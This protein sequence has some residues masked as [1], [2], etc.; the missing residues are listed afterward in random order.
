M[1][2]LAHELTVV[3]ATGGVTFEVRVKPRSSRS[4]ILSVRDG[5][6]D[7][8]LRAPPVEGAANLELCKLLARTLGVPKS[9]VSIVKGATGRRKRVV[10]AGITADETRARLTACGS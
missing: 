6:L 4:V 3:Q 1:T 10:A 2:G 5:A 7:V 8:A 9:A